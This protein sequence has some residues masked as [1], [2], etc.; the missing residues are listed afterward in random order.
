ARQAGRPF[1]PAPDT[2]FARLREARLDALGDLVAHHLDTAAL[3]RLI[4]GGAP[5]GLPVLPPPG[6]T[7]Q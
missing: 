3:G 6:V 5:R 1:V 7:N 4:N 2:D